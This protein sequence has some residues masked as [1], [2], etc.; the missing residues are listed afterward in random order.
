[1]GLSD[2]YTANAIAAA[3]KASGEEILFATFASRTGAMASVVSG[4]VTGVGGL[5]PRDKIRREAGADTKLPLNFLLAVTPTSVQFFAH[6]L[7]WGRVKIKRTLG[8]LPRAGL[9]VHVGQGAIRQFQLHAPNPPQTVA[10]EI[11]TIGSASKDIVQRLTELLH[12]EA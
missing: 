5:G 4:I 9:Q 7:F 8:V 1:M 11:A 3:A 10:F 6:K 12:T 2:R